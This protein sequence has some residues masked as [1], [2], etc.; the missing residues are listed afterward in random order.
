MKIK[1]I[2]EYEGDAFFYDH[3]GNPEWPVA[4]I[5]ALDHPVLGS[6]YVR[7]SVILNKHDNGDFETLNTIY[8]K[9]I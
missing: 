8:R 3:N 2:V 7:T 4:S 5:Y 9:T 6:R 1:P